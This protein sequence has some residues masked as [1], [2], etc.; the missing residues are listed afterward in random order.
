MNYMEYVFTYKVGGVNDA[1]DDEYVYFLVFLLNLDLSI[2]WCGH[3]RDVSLHTGDLGGRG[4]QLGP[5]F[6]TTDS[7]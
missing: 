2:F 5:S 7:V 1:E 6:E 4:N 3:T